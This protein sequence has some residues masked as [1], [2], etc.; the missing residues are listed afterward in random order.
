MATAGPDRRGARVTGTDD[1]LGSGAA[2]A[3]ELR[4]M[5]QAFVSWQRERRAMNCGGLPRRGKCPH[6]SKMTQ[7]TPP[8]LAG[9]EILLV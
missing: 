4:V 6:L 8:K 9:G 3:P 2:R 5:L 1:W 7:T